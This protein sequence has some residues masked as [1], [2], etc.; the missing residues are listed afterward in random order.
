M[1]DKIH[2]LYKTLFGLLVIIYKKN[3]MRFFKFFSLFEVMFES[4]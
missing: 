2:S 1:S 4:L 3:G